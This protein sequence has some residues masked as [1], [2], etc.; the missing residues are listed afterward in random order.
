MKTWE[1]TNF[2]R[3]ILLLHRHFDLVPVLIGGK[4]NREDNQNIIEIAQTEGQIAAV[5]NLTEESLGSIASVIQHADLFVGIDSGFMHMASSFDLPVVA[6]FGPTDPFYVGPQNKRSIVVRKE[7]ME[8]V[9]CYLQN[10]EHKNCMVNL[11][12]DTVFK[13][14]EKLMNR[15]KH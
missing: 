8:C 12:V 10:C 11:S 3:L 2:A 13:A 9:P 6:L 14:C 5:D 15:E 7:S 1:N 4:D